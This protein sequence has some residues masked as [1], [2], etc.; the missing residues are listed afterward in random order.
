[1]QD[2]ITRGRNLFDDQQYEESTQTLSAALL[3]PSNTKDQ[4]IEIYRL[5][6]YNYITMNRKEEAESA[7]R[8]LLAIDPEYALPPS[9]SPRFRD[10]FSNAKLKWEAEGKPGLVQAEAAPPAPVTMAHNSPSQVEK[11]AEIPLSVKLADEQHRTHSVKLFYRSGSK[12]KFESIDVSIVNGTGHGTIPG[13][14]VKPPLVEYYFEAYDAGS[15]PIA[16]RGDAAA[17]LRVAVPDGGAGWVLPVAI[18]G[19][20]VGAAAIVLGGLALGGAFKSSNSG[21]GGPNGGPRTSTVSVSIG[22]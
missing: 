2:L 6:A 14:A 20:V 18:G 15:L 22:Q 4:K 12:G 16:S 19:G 9:E 10:F 21:G 13:T 11:G 1:R 8:G 17:P 7:V 3:R 5:L